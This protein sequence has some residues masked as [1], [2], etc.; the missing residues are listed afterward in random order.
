M[1]SFFALAATLAVGAPVPESP[2]APLR[3]Q[4]DAPKEC[5]TA[6]EVL[7]WTDALAPR[8][9]STS[10]AR[11]TIE[12]QGAEYA[13]KLEITGDASVSRTLRS[14]DCRLLGRAAAVVIAVSL[15]PIAVARTTAVTTAIAGGAVVPEPIPTP[16]PVLPITDEPRRAAGPRVL[17]APP[18]ERPRSPIEYGASFGVGVDGL[19]LPRA[20]AGVAIAPFVGTRRIHVEAALQY[21]SPRSTPDNEAIGVQARVQMVSGGVRAC[22]LL[23]W[24]RWR[25]PLCAGL[26]VGGVF[27]RAV[28][29]SVRNGSPAVAP[30]AGV[31]LAPGVR[32]SVAPRVSLGLALE[33]VISLYMPRFAVEGLDDDLYQMGQGGLRGVFSVQIHNARKKR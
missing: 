5:P 6:S 30:W 11:A 10:E 20:G 31:V 15:D 26:D 22:P 28:G 25:V 32:V 9:G 19:L 8:T 21:W 7:A 12:L 13:L 33:G 2:P 24:G 18:I 4:W 14:H 1:V 27:A 3:L 29:S 23:E 17:S 16:P